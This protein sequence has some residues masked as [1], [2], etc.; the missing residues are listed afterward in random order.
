MSV[1]L[2]LSGTDRESLRGELGSIGDVGAFS[3]F[4]S[5]NLGGYGDGGMIVTDDEQIAEVAGM[6]RVH[7]A[8][9]KYHNEVLGYNSRLDTLQ[10][11]VF[12]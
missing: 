10:A 12:G 3:F 1:G 6:L 11:A 2:C 9:K 7:G 5:K 8:K 4:P